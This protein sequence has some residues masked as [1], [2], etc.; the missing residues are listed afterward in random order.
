MK[1]YADTLEG[2]NF[3]RVHRS[4]MVNLNHVVRFVRGEKMKVIL[5]DQSL[6]EVAHRRKDELIQLLER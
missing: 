3:F 6:I 5:S 1:E 2:A 4:H